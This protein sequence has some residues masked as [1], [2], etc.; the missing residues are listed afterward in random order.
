MSPKNKSWA[1]KEGEELPW[2]LW[3]ISAW[4]LS[5]WEVGTK[6]Q[7]PRMARWISL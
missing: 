3:V 1:P 4:P 5:I 2:N 6:R 7:E